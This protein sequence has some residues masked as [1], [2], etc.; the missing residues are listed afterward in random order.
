MHK[1][2]YIIFILSRQRLFP[3]G[4]IDI[5][6]IIEK[7]LI[8]KYIFRSREIYNKINLTILKNCITWNI[9]NRRGERK[10]EKGGKIIKRRRKRENNYFK[11]SFIWIIAPKIL[12][13]IL[14]DF[15]IIL[16]LDISINLNDL[17]F[18]NHSSHVRANKDKNRI[19][20]LWR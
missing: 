18:L 12:S 9:T 15:N 5:D 17:L 20:Q 14:I 2:K 13:H 8:K 1:S 10:D 7:N 19:Y 4:I 6:T 11:I 3:R 16:I